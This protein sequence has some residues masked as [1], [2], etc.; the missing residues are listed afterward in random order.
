[1]A[2]P[3]RWDGSRATI[4][5]ADRVYVPETHRARAEALQRENQQRGLVDLRVG[6][7]G[8]VAVLRLRIGNASLGD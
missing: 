1:V 5:G 8:T 4:D 6:S 3:A 7:D 2:L